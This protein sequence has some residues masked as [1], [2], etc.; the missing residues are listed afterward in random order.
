MKQLLIIL[1]IYSFF[2]C[3]LDYKGG[4][5]YNEVMG[6]DSLNIEEVD[7]FRMDN[8]IKVGPRIPDSLVI[9]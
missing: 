5:K 3:E 2:S 6:N 9:E 4:Y 8:S 7:S 1:T